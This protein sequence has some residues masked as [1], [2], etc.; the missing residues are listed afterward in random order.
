M[1]ANSRLKKLWQLFK[2]GYPRSTS[3]ALLPEINGKPH[4]AGERKEGL[5]DFEPRQNLSSPLLRSSQCLPDMPG[6]ENQPDGQ[7]CSW[8]SL[9]TLAT[10]RK[11]PNLADVASALTSLM[12]P[13]MQNQGRENLCDDQGSYISTLCSNCYAMTSFTNHVFRL[14]PSGGPKYACNLP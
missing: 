13:D 10:K 14:V 3:A 7:Q 11:N 5:P 4:V 9:E 1:S 2:N 12:I 6:A 8:P